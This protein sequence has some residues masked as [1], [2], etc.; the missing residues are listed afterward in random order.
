M[1]TTQDLG[2]VKGPTGPQGPIGS[3]GNDGQ[4][5]WLTD[6]ALGISGAYSTVTNFLNR[7]YIDPKVG[8]LV[9]GS[10]GALGGIELY[11][12][13]EATVGGLQTTLRGPIGPRGITGNSTYIASS[14]IGIPEKGSDSKWLDL[15]P[16]FNNYNTLPDVDDTIIDIDGSVGVVVSSNSSNNQRS[17]EGLG[18]NVGGNTHVKSGQVGYIGNKPLYEYIW[19][20]SRQAEDTVSYYH[21]TTIPHAWSSGEY[22]F[23]HVIG[24]LCTKARNQYNVYEVNTTNY[25]TCSFS[26]NDESITSVEIYINLEDLAVVSYIDATLIV[27]Y[28]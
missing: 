4:S 8:D 27:Q 28:T 18:V 22:T 21:G 10:D 3:T 14:Y 5:I 25:F 19:T 2:N 12:G 16:Y 15:S 23:L 24:S 26:R 17:I 6:Q 13:N 7:Y 11:D 20:Y 1:A 9:I